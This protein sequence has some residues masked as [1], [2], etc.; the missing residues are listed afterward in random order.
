MSWYADS[1]RCARLVAHVQ[2]RQTLW[3]IIPV[4]VVHKSYHAESVANPLHCKTMKRPADGNGSCCRNV[5][6][7]CSSNGSLCTAPCRSL[8]ALLCCILPF[9]L[10]CSSSLPFFVC[11][12]LPFNSKCCN[13]R[14][15]TP[16]PKSPEPRKLSW[17]TKTPYPKPQTPNPVTPIR[18]WGLGFGVWGFGSGVW[19]LG[20]WVWGFGSGVFG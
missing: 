5:D 19:G 11:L 7:A 4:R 12:I 15:L 8:S 9:D 1:S 3:Q 17:P 6:S 14:P 18:V 2:Q 10:A 13:P 16:N 20:F